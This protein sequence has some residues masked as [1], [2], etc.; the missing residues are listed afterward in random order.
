MHILITGGTGLIGRHLIRTIK[1]K[2]TITV[3]T[4][5]PDKASEILPDSVSLTE[6]LADF[7]DFSQFDAVINLAG[8]PIADKRWTETQKQRICKSRWQLTQKLV[9][10]IKASGAPPE[11]FISG[12]AVGYYG[13]QGKQTATEEQHH[14]HDEFTHTVCKQW[15]CIAFKARSDITRVCTIRTGIVL[16][17]DEGALGKMALPFKLGLGGKLGDGEQMMSWIHIEDEV[18]AIIFLLNN[19][20][21]E[22][23]YNLTAPN[24]VSNA[25]FS[26]Q[27]AYALHRPNLFTVPAFVLKTVLGETSDLLLTGQRVLPARLASA[28]FNFNFPTLDVALNHLYS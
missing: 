17:K 14:V 9:E 25:E 28:G 24:P 21:C 16:A 23:A 2:H 15:E 11:I 26:K 7:A 13:R 4:R 10:K 20:S 12:S 22:G 3:L 19:E 27:L 1:D 6:S 18:A 8:E 5:N